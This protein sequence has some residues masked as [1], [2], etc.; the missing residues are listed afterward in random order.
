[1]KKI[2][3]IQFLFALLIAFGISSCKSKEP[4]MNSEWMDAKTAEKMMEE[5]NTSKN[6][7]G[8]IVTLLVL[9][10]MTFLVARDAKK[11]K[12]N[13][14]VWGIFTFIFNI[15]TILLYF[16]IRWLYRGKLISVSTFE[17]RRVKMLQT[18]LILSVI[19]IVFLFISSLED[20]NTFEEKR[21]RGNLLLIGLAIGIPSAIC[22][23][24]SYTNKQNESVINR[25]TNISNPELNNIEGLSFC[26]SC[27][28]QVANTN[29]QFCSSCGSKI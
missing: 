16:T 20:K 9:G 10:T 1:M 26:Q 22:A 5:N 28:K 17:K 2:I 14:W 8:R 19:S 13:P 11:N 12:M 6:A 18:S 24:I 27:G 3:I 21:A 15:L 23:I 25:S 4:D 7:I 29:A